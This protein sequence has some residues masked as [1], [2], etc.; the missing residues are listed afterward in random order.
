MQMG[1]EYCKETQN[2][3]FKGQGSPQEWQDLVKA[4]PAGHV[5][6]I[7]ARVK[8]INA[9]K[10]SLHT[11]NCYVNITE[12]KE[13]QG[14][15]LI[16]MSCEYIDADTGKKTAEAVLIINKKPEDGAVVVTE[17][18]LL[19]LE[20]RGLT[21]LGGSNDKVLIVSDAMIYHTPVKDIEPPLSTLARGIKK[22][23]KP[24]A[25]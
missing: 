18:S 22:A 20:G 9:L 24:S 23:Y 25:P 10:A 3:V 5:L 1:Y 8:G 15:K 13:V 2:G 19:A 4:R 11:E 21:R 16:T 6:D 12:H 17:G 7:S 14:G